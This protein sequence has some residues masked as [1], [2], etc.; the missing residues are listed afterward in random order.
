[1]AL[2][3]KRCGAGDDGA[4]AGSVLLVFR[5]RKDRKMSWLK[6]MRGEK[7]QRTEVS[8]LHIQTVSLEYSGTV[9]TKWK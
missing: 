2:R 1:M 3:T 6:E 8:I 5:V 4:V 7:G 9:T